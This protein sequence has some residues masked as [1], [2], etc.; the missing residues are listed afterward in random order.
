MSLAEGQTLLDL[1]ECLIISAW[2][3]RRVYPCSSSYY[4]VYLEKGGHLN[5]WIC[6]QRLWIWR[7]H[8]HRRN[9]S[10]VYLVGYHLEFLLYIIR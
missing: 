3:K 2:A 4:V 9:L 7:L 8:E 5:G 1:C 10:S 6:W